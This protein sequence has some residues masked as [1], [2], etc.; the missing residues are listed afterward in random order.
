MILYPRVEL[1]GVERSES[2][3]GRPEPLR[4]AKQAFESSE[5]RVQG[6]VIGKISG[7]GRALDIFCWTLCSG[8]SWDVSLMRVWGNSGRQ[9]VGCV[10]RYIFV[11]VFGI[12]VLIF[13]RVRARLYFYE[14]IRLT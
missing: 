1:T 11:T 13:E 4:A 6:A 12:F 7:W 5:E 3:L 10:G 8:H 2:G 9:W 14:V